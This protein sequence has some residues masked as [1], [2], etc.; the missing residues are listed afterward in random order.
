MLTIYEKL[1]KIAEI[2]FSDIVED[3]DYLSDS[4]RTFLSDKSYLDI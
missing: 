1:H 2:E 4:L 3:V